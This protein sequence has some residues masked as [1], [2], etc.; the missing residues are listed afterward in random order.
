MLKVNL[1]EIVDQEKYKYQQCIVDEMA[2]AQGITVLRLSPYHCDLNPIEL[3]WA[4]AK[5]HVARHNRS[6]KMEEVKK[7]LLESISNVTPDK[8]A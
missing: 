8:R 5:G 6:F 4:Q 7:L 1:L 3:V 2:A